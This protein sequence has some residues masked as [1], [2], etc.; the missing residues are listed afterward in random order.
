MNNETESLLIELVTAS[1]TGWTA[2]ETDR[3]LFCVERARASAKGDLRTELAGLA[4]SLYRFG[5]DPIMLRAAGVADRVHA[6]ATRALEL[7]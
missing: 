2:A 1:E 7:I 4:K 6:R 5:K 3:Y